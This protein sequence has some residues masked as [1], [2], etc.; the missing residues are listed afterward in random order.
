MDVKTSVSL[1][2]H[3]HGIVGS[4]LARGRRLEE[5]RC[6]TSEEQA[7]AWSCKFSGGAH[8]SSREGQQSSLQLWSDK[9]TK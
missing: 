8:V 6:Q 5:C 7:L 4:H 1:G 3:D 2:C 9:K